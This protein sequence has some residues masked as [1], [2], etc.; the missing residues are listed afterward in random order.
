[1]V[2]D[3]LLETLVTVFGIVGAIAVF[4]QVYKIFKRKSAKDI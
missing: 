4:P 2:L 3:V 1:M